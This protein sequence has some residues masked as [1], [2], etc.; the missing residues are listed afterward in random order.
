M[1]PPMSRALAALL[2]LTMHWS[3]GRAQILYDAQPGTLPAEQGWSYAALPGT[4]RQT[5]TGSA[6]RLDTLMSLSEAA[7]YALRPAPP[8]DRRTGFNLVLRF[9][10]LEA[11]STRPE[12][13][14]FSVIVL[15]AERRG[16][17][18]GFGAGDVFAQHDQPL[19]TRGESAGFPLSN[20]P[21]EAVLSLRG[22]HYTLFLNRS[23]LLTGPVRDYTAFSGFPDVYETPNF[24]FLGDNTTSAAALVDLEHVAQ[25]L[26]PRLNAG[27]A[28]T[29]TWDAVPGQRYTLERST[30]LI[31]WLPRINV[32][33][34]DP[35][36]IWPMP[37]GEASGFYRVVHPAL[38]GD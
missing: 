27:P 20:G 11:R 31:H 19:F 28:G 33:A 2:S 6:T 4:A 12:R 8:L 14:G 1:M 16:I 3:A 35:R 25:V 23:P 32:Y 24:L 18:L 37:A 36:L 30:D 21:V 7:G 17:E 34:A 29:L 15:D 26:P 9:H 13:A 10:L 22:D 5:H 38:P